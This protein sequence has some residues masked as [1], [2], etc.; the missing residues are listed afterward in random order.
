MGY[1]VQ[2]LQQQAV[3]F[4]EVMP[5]AMTVAMMVVKAVVTVAVLILQA[6]FSVLKKLF[7][8]KNR[9]SEYHR[10]SEYLRVMNLVTE[11]KLAKSDACSI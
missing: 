5:V 1:Y 4:V 6:R 2:N 10:V 9:V 7:C 8:V 11:E 3:F